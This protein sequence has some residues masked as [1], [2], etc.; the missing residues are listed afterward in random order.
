ML[1]QPRM[2]GGISGIVGR[3]RSVQADV[4][5][6][7][8]ASIRNRNDPVRKRR[9]EMLPITAT[10]FLSENPNHWLEFFFTVESNTTKVQ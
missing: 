2:G 5:A 7:A 9:R 1:F 10:P 6:E 4:K 3:G 8:F